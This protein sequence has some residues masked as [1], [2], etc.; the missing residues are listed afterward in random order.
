M[1]TLVLKAKRIAKILLRNYFSAT[2]ARAKRKEVNLEWWNDVPNLGDYLSVVVYEWMLA[3]KGITSPQSKKTM[4]LMA[5]GSIIGKY[6][7]DSVVWGT[8]FGTYTKDVLPLIIKNRKRVKYDIRAV[9]GPLTQM[10][11]T[12]C[13]Y[14]CDS[15][16]GDPAILLPLIYPGKSLGTKKYRFSLI[17]HMLRA[18]SNGNAD[19]NQIDVRTSDYEFFIDEILASECIISSSLHGIILAE[20]YGVP[21]VF[22]NDEKDDELFKFYDWYYST[23]RRNVRI[24]YSLEE[25]M[26][27]TPM[28]LPDLRNMQQ[29]LL[30]SFPYDIFICQDNSLTN[31]GK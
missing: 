31:A 20:T 19:L 17:N 3:R 26:A 22:F 29:G 13:G 23:G 24:A 27:M 6:N 8:G 10:V 28:E 9:R 16:F 12:S 21:A 15:V 18:E 2:N 7:F 14:K 11:L 30:D 1:N 25:A 5:V 4:H